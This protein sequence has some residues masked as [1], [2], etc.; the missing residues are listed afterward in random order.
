[1]TGGNGSDTYYVNSLKDIVVEA[2]APLTGLNTAV[3]LSGVLAGMIVLWPWIDALLEKLAPR[4][5]LGI[6][7]GIIAFLTFL[8]FTVWEAMA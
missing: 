4:R 6:Y 8:V 3:V 7:V 1:M 2:K 5:D